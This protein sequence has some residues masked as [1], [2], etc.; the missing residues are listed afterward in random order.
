M[1]NIILILFILI[2][3]VVCFGQQKQFS[4]NVFVQT[5]S[6]E[7]PVKDEVYS[8]AS[9]ELRSLGDVSLLGSP[10]YKILILAEKISDT[11]TGG[12]Y[13]LTYS[14]LKVGECTYKSKISNTKPTQESC[15]SLQTFNSISL[16]SAESLK[17][18]T[19]SIIANF[20]ANILEPD[21]K[22]FNIANR[23]K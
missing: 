11:P 22:L 1:R 18:K 23:V 6:S 16:F 9:R 15:D 7:K 5:I 14:F 21:R 10:E 12:Y 3:A 2:F 4:A 17:A 20:D 8:F 13:A 19:E